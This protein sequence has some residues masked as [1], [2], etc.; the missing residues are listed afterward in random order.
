MNGY[1]QTI[2]DPCQVLVHG[3]VS[4]H[5]DGTL[6]ARNRIPVLIGREECRGA[7]ACPP[8]LQPAPPRKLRETEPFDERGSLP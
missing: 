1:E 8:D 6:E 7:E 5:E 3:D 2:P 4:V